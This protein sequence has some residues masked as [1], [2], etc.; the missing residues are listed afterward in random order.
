MKITVT[1]QDSRVMVEACIHVKQPVPGTLTHR[2]LQIVG[3]GEGRLF[4]KDA[5]SIDAF[6][7]TLM[8]I[9]DGVDDETAVNQCFD[10]FAG[11]VP[12]S[13]RDEVI[14]KAIANALFDLRQRVEFLQYAA[15]IAGQEINQ[16]PE[17]EVIDV[18]E[19]H[20]RCVECGVIFPKR[21]IAGDDWHCMKHT[22]QR[23][24]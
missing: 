7:D 5:V 11:K 8:S 1:I 12:T 21:H 18:P 9:P 24:I 14:K 10:A 13:D 15:L 4:I 16:T 20:G 3:N 23:Y 17:P 6:M 2:D 19:D 22:D